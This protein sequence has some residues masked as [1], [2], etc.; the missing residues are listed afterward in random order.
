MT[1]ATTRKEAVQLGQSTFFTGRPCPRGHL[2]PRRVS[3]QSCILCDKQNSHNS[4]A[5]NID[6]KKQYNTKWSKDHPELMRAYH[7]DWRDQQR[8]NLLYIQRRMLSRVKLRSKK[9]D[10]PFDLTI[11]YIQTIWPQDNKCPVYDVEFDLSGNNL[12]WCASIDKTI[13]SKGYVQGNVSIISFRAN[14]IKTDSTLN[15]LK[16]L[17]EYLEKGQALQE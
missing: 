2:S 9:E 15:E 13:P 17:V 1:Q 11:E 10:L 16:L 5:R 3:N 14:S 12:Q 4:Y 8:G 7:K 6:S